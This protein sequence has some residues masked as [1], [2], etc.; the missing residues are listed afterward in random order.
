MGRGC[1]QL[2]TS[3][4]LVFP[5]KQPAVKMLNYIVIPFLILFE[6]PPYYFPS[7]CNQLNLY[8]TT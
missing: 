4:F 1:I 5:D 8:P 6:K 7:S 3:V 2:F